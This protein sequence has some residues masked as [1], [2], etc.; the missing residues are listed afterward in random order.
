MN[1]TEM[2]LFLAVL[3]EHK[4]R[5]AHDVYIDEMTFFNC[6]TCLYLRSLKRRQEASEAK[7][8]EEMAQQTGQGDK[9]TE[10]LKRGE[11][12]AIDTADL[13]RAKE[14]ATKFVSAD[15]MKDKA[16]IE[17]DSSFRISPKSSI[18]VKGRIVNKPGNK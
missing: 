10:A 5:T 6:N 3:N 13:K 18:T 15:E 14:T 8:H 16:D 12:D 9:H 7:F 2:D 4:H 17:D 11:E 1:Q